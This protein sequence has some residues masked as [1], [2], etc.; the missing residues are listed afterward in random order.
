MSMV[1]ITSLVLQQ[2]LVFV[3]ARG[4]ITTFVSLIQTVAYHGVHDYSLRAYLQMLTMYYMYCWALCAL[5]H[6]VP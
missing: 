4:S 2:R 5:K 1:T 6:P 3:R